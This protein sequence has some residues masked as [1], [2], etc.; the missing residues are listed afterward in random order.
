MGP[1]HSTASQLRG[2]FA[3]GVHPS[4][5]I[6]PQ[7]DTGA[8]SPSARHSP[9]TAGAG[10][11]GAGGTWGA[12]G[13]AT[14]VLEAARAASCAVRWEQATSASTTAERG[15][16][17]MA[18]SHTI[19]EGDC[20]SSLA[21]AAGLLDHHAVY[22]HGD[23]AALKARRPNPNMLL[24]G[25]VVQVPE[26]ET[27]TVDAATTRRHRFV[28]E[29]RPVKLR[30]KLVDRQGRALS[31]TPWRLT[32]AGGQQDGVLGGDGKI[33]AVIP[34]TV[35][36][37]RLVLDPDAPPPTPPTTP[38]PP[39]DPPPDP[40]AT[41]TYP[42]TVKA[43][44]YRDR[45]DAGYVGNDLIPVQWSLS[46]GALPTP[47]EVAGAQERLVNLGAWIEG[48][49]GA[50]GAWTQAAVKAFQ[51]RSGQSPTGDVTEVQDAVRDAHDT[52]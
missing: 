17:V 44:E 3:R 40:N 15:E 21:A 19:A 48:E 32:W 47:N 10:A 46:V 26:V 38:A 9:S 35:T 7:H 11:R 50:P 25:D 42:P 45:V 5:V 22:D 51:R 52:F 14:T 4:G 37:A 16:R 30:I 18:R 12:G 33:E 49:R 41:E 29:S 28:V 31:N 13:A 43:A 23:N 24:V 34:A 39:A 2:A 1:G 20:C 36:A 8:H 6:A 27:R